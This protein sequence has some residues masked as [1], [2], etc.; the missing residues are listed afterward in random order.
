MTEPTDQPEEP[1]ETASAPE[2][3]ASWANGRWLLWLLPVLA[4][5]AAAGLWYASRPVAVPL[6]G[7]VEATEVNVATKALARVET[8][9]VAEGAMVQPSDLLAT[10]SSPG[11]DALVSQSQAGLESARAIDAI[12]RQG[13]RPEDIAS[14][15]AI[16]ASTRAAAA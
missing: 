3:G 12:A 10:L 8:V 15:Q 2:Y 13:T 7:T 9:G 14:L 6:Q 11:L 4:L 16:A 5:L 1:I